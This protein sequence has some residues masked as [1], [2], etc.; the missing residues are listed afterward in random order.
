[1]NLVCILVLIIYTVLHTVE[2]DMEMYGVV[3]SSSEME[4]PMGYFSPI[5]EELSNETYGDQDFP[6]I[7]FQTGT[8]LWQGNELVIDPSNQTV[9][10]GSS[11]FGICTSSN[12]SPRGRWCKIRAAFKWGLVRR[13]VAAKK[14]AQWHSYL[15]F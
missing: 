10:I 2:P 5:I 12:G 14:M 15:N 9:N 4:I 6:D 13:D 7:D 3:G 1:M 11:D 8:S